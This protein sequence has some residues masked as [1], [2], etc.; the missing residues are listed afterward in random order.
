MNVALPA[1]VW[2]EWRVPR[3]AATFFVGVLLAKA[4]DEAE[5]S[6]LPTQSRAE[7]HNEEAAK[8]DKT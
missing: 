6:A 3:T 7:L 2:E 4:A 5:H 1:I 8:W